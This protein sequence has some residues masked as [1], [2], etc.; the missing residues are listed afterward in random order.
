ML[1]HVGPCAEAVEK[2][3]AA[4]STATT[5]GTTMGEKRRLMILSSCEE[6]AQ[7]LIA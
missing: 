6:R 2:A 5:A 4:A 7:S 1:L 3:T